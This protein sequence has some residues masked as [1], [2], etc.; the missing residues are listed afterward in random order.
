M[1]R[2]F[3]SGEN[4]GMA[5]RLRDRGWTVH[6]TAVAETD[7]VYGRDLTDPFDAN[8]NATGEPP[9]LETSFLEGTR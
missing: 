5:A 3:A 7:A 9:W 1:T 2:L 8:T 6:E 4:D